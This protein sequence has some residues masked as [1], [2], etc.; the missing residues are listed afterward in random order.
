MVIRNAKKP[1]FIWFIIAL[2]PLTN[3]RDSIVHLAGVY[4]VNIPFL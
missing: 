3:L 1:P 4:S 2:C